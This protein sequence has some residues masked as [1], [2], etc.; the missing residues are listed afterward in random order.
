VPEALPL[1]QVGV[2]EA[3]TRATGQRRLLAEC[4]GAVQQAGGLAARSLQWLDDGLADVAD[5]DSGR[6]AAGLDVDGARRVSRVF[7]TSAPIG[8][9]TPPL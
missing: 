7:G 1:P 8:S 3:R 4:G 2:V 5:P 9:K 6:L